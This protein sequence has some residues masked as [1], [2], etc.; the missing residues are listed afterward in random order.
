[1]PHAATGRALAACLLL[2]AFSAVAQTMYRWVDEKGVTHFSESPPPDG[3]KASKV[4][5]KV[6]PPS[7]PQA[8]PAR[9]DPDAWKAQDAEFRRRQI[10]RQRDAARQSCD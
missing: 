8:A 2:A 5:P 9:N 10:D 3:S 4:E 1:M 6:T 7:S